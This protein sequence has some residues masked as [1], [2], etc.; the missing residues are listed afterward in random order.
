MQLRAEYPSSQSDTPPEHRLM[1]ALVRDAVRS[2]EKYRHARDFRGKRLF[3]QDSDW[4]LSNDT[5][6]IYAFL[7]V[8]ETLNLDPDSVRIA[9]GLLPAGPVRRVAATGAAAT[10]H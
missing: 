7:R 4:V 6:W 2:I 3:A 9:L 8:C 10:L 5:G 1:I